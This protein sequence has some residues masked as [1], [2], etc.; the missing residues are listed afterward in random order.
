MA[1]G[2]RF[3]R[4]GQKVLILEK[5]TKPGGLNSY[6]SRKGR[7][8]ETGLH[9]I[10][11]YAEPENKQAPLN[12]LLR[13]L[14]IPRRSLKFRQQK[15]SEILFPGRGTLL[16]SNDFNLFQTQIAEHFPG[17]N[18]QFR[19]MTAELG[20]YDPFNP[21]PKSSA[22]EFVSAFIKDQ[23]LQEM[24]FCPIMF[25]GSSDEDDMDLS[26]F[27]ILFRSIFQEGLFR[28]E[29]TIKDLL[30]LL[31]QQYLNFGGE[32][33]FSTGVTEITSTDNKIKAVLTEKVNRSDV[34]IS[35]PPPV[36]LRPKNFSPMKAEQQGF[37]N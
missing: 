10:T 31:K 3:A 7:L 32:I 36:Y 11:N 20:R 13:Q 29:G 24:L 30:D 22:R 9:A 25:Y 2:I 27:V 18:E 14:K 19:E 4:F 28:P 8:L 37:Q 5:H 34:I 12:R 6:Y 21:K 23:L 35:Y 26:Q 17:S 15:L 16:F 33:E 1:A